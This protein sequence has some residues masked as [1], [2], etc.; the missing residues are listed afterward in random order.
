MSLPGRFAI[1]STENVIRPRLD[2]MGPQERIDP[3]APLVAA[4]LEGRPV[5]L[6]RPDPRTRRPGMPAD[7]TVPLTISRFRRAL[8]IE[9]ERATSPYEPSLVEQWP[10]THMPIAYEYGYGQEQ[11]TVAQAKMGVGIIAGATIGAGIGLVFG[12]KRSATF[13]GA[14]IGGAAGLLLSTTLRGPI[15]W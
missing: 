11:F 5:V 12:R 9:A 13:V 8:D 7:L 4:W 6:A 10:L 1:F 15:A 3:E 2:A 14:A